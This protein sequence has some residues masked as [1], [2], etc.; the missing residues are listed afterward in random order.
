MI[1]TVTSSAHA[2]PASTSCRFQE[3]E[4]VGKLRLLGEGFE[5]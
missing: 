1:S 3:N 2:A 4:T 5:T